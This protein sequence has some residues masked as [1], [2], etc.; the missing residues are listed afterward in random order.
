MRDAD[1][2]IEIVVP[3]LDGEES[4]DIHLRDVVGQASAHLAVP[5]SG[6]EAQV[7]QVLL[8]AR[9]V[10]Q[11]GGHDVSRRRGRRRSGRRPRAFGADEVAGALRLPVQESPANAPFAEVGVDDADH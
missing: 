8:H 10:L 9:I 11:D 6:F 7:P 5:P 3:R 4:V 1:D 2:L